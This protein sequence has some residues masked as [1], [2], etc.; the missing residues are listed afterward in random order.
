[1]TIYS[2]GAEPGFTGSP[3]DR[4]DHLRGDPAA[5]ARLRSDPAARLIRLEALDPVLDGKGRL[6]WDGID[7]AAADAELALL[8][9]IDGAPMFAALVEAP[10]GARRSPAIM[11]LM[12]A[13]APAEASTYAA[14]RSLVDWHARHRFCAVCGHETTPARAGWARN[15]GHC[16]A[17]HYPR[18]DPVVIMLAEQ[19]GRALVG[20]GHHFPPRFYSALAGFVEV[21]ESMEEAVARELFEEGGVRATRVRYLSSQPW[22]FASSL[23]MACTADVADDALLLDA[24]ELAD[25]MWV[26]RAEVQ[27]ALAGDPAARFLAPPPYAIAHTLLRWWAERTSE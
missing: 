5:I 20:R 24:N 10:N 14:A 23:M 17:E 6:V 27:A 11:G 15:C 26:T 18:T 7:Q 21:G 25:A 8:G 19:G 22:P 9:L 16:G 4:A 1:M 3:L 13:M 12:A 2:P